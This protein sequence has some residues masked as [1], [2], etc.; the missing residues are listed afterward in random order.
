[1]SNDASPPI[2]TTDH[3]HL[4]DDR[5]ALVVA[6]EDL[7]QMGDHRD[8]PAMRQGSRELG[9]KLAEHRF[10][11][12]VLG[13]FK[14]GKSTLINA[15]LGERL[16]PMGAV[17]LT[18]VITIITFGPDPKAEVFF[19]D[20]R[21][22]VIGSGE[23]DRYVTERHNPGNRLGVRHVRIECP[24]SKLADGVQL[25][26]TP[27]V[28]SIHEHNTAT[29]RA[30]L[31]EV[32]AAVFVTSADQPVT[33][34][35]RRFLEEVR[36]EAAR[37]FFVL[38]KVDAVDPADLAEVSA[39][40]RHVLSEAMARDVAVYPVSA[41]RALQDGASDVDAAGMRR[42]ERDFWAFIADERG[43]TILASIAGAALKLV[44][45][46]VNA[47]R[48]E[49]QSAHLTVEEL[50]R[51]LQALDR[52]VAEARRS[53]RELDA[54]LGMEIRRVVDAV[55][56]DLDEF[57]HF[58]T[59]RLLGLARSRL[60]E[61]P[62]PRRAAD[63]LDAVVKDELRRAIDTWRAR[64]EP[65]VAEAARTATGRFVEETNALIAR[66]IELCTGLLEIRLDFVATPELLRVQS[67]FTYSFVPAP[68]SI[69]ATIES[70]R[71]RMPSGL[72]RRMLRRDLEREIPG[73]V[74]MHRG[75]LRWD[76][77]QRLEYGRTELT[78]QLDARLDGLLDGLRRGLERAAENR[79]ASEEEARVS[80]SELAESMDRLR[81]IER[82]L[83]DIKQKTA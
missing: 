23:L 39:F 36:S 21:R 50:G 35:E 57:V 77:S 9:I 54:L 74:D 15:L 71:R 42:F 69:R 76:L 59:G 64:K 3:P 62:D 38:N 43:E 73:L 32:D 30:F 47:I 22:E 44:A 60:A 48:V 6:L 63:E 52:V 67:A 26:D 46:E 55:D 29:T 1:M 11:V 37:M 34:G 7:M 81:A 19:A 4:S 70:V 24:T 51:R 80:M 66:T 12:A 2:V 41:L 10:V 83:A 61:H 16:L 72:S 17:P 20:G 75:R 18:S 28:G 25:V 31:S 8:S 53:K 68:D 14:R 40:T 65:E 78:R 27:G 82:R 5:R 56:H 79:L 33:A 45:D 49:Q 13:E 58:E